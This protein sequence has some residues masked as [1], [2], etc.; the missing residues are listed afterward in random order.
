MLMDKSV[1]YNPLKRDPPALINFDDD[2]TEAPRGSDGFPLVVAWGRDFASNSHD[3]VKPCL[4]I[5]LKSPPMV[6][7]C[8]VWTLWPGSIV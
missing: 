6:H 1:S 7:W 5:Y 4:F 2:V 3:A 8:F